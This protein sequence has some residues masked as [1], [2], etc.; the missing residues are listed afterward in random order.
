MA[1]N[2]GTGTPKP[3]D[4]VTLSRGE[5]DALMLARQALDTIRTERDA[6]QAGAV[7]MSARVEALEA[8][9]NRRQVDDEVRAAEQAGKVVTADLRALLAK[10]SAD[11]RAVILAAL[12]ASRPVVALGHG[13]RVEPV[14]ANGPAV[15]LAAARIAREKNIPYAEALTL[16]R[17]AN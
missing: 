3:E 12:P 9:R 1:G 7:S 14:D 4:V 8:E 13:E 15:V 11:A 16:A 17:G 6:L 10:T 2:Q 5:H